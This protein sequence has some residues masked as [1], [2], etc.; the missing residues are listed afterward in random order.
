MLK[1]ATIPVDS[2]DKES[3]DETIPLILNSFIPAFSELEKTLKEKCKD[4]DN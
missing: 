4:A 2:Y 1:K 3:I